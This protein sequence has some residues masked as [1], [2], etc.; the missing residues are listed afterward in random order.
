ME[1]QKA[2]KVGVWEADFEDVG[3]LKLVEDHVQ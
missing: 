2:R 1:D 3:G